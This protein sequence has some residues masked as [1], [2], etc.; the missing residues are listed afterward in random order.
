M[1]FNNKEQ[2]DKRK[3][4]N[5]KLTFVLACGKL[6]LIS[7]VVSLLSI[8]LIGVNSRGDLTSGSLE[9]LH[10]CKSGCAYSAIQTAINQAHLNATI[11][12]AKGVYKESLLIN[13]SVTL[14]GV[15]G[16]TELVSPELNT[17][18]IIVKGEKTRVQIENFKINCIRWHQTSELHS[19]SQYNAV[20]TNFDVGV[21][22]RES[23]NV[24]IRNSQIVGQA[25]EWGTAIKLL[26]NSHALLDDNIISGSGYAGVWVKDEALAIILKNTIFG[27]LMGIVGSDHAQAF[28]QNNDIHH[29]MIALKGEGSF[30]SMILSNRLHSN[31]YGSKLRERGSYLILKNEIFSNKYGI[32]AQFF[33][34]TISGRGN[35]FK[36]NFED[37]LG[38][39][40]NI[41]EILRQ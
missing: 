7:C 12:A 36:E 30:T 11:Y 40:A 8:S 18:V 39:S 25:G 19:H 21:L 14:I 26:D 5:R 15:S 1:L 33:E 37:F 34:G 32:Y 3:L 27:N 22:I 35:Q 10:V 41:K 20:E 24:T 31:R 4:L 6:I 16:K 13:K 17:P 28:V 9:T 2:F 23:A 29:N 38:L